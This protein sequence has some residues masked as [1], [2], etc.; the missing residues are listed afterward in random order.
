MSV[1]TDPKGA[2]D[3]SP[4]TVDFQDATLAS[5]LKVLWNLIARPVRGAT[6]AERLESFYGHQAD[7][8]DSFRSRMLHGRNELIDRIVFPAAGIWVDVGAGT[9]NNIV[10]AGHRTRALREIHLVDLS[11][12]LLEVAQKRI[13][14]AGIENARVH[15]AD[16]T[17]FQLPAESVDVITFSY[18]L[19]MIPDW[20]EAIR[21]AERMLK[22]GGTIAAT[23]LYVSRKY[24]ADTC[25]QHGWLRR[26]FWT[27]WFAADNVHLSGDHCAMLQRTFDC[28]LFHERMGRVPYL[29]LIRAPYYLFVG[30]KPGR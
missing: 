21:Q 26:A 6:H 7:Q 4:P 1:T 19:T 24:A 5:D 29:P 30:T 22:P 9:G 3:G 13:S 20:F 8:Y 12:S 11:R 23:D 16:A 17:Q 14:S 2:G 18:S 28:E 27:H 25:R 15:L 10:H